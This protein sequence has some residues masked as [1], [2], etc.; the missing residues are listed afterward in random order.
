MKNFSRITDGLTRVLSYLGMMGI[1]AMMLHICADVL[2]RTL[3]GLSVPA[4]LEMV[5]RYYMLMLVLLSLAWV[6]DK[7]QMIAVEAFTGM[8][9]KAGL[10]VV[11]LLV[12]VFCIIV[13]SVLAVSTWHKAT[14]QY[15]IGAYVVALDTQII[16]WPGY[17]TLPF[18]FGLAALVCLMKI[19]LNLIT[20]TASAAA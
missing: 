11:H 7:H 9:G 16:V 12:T 17:F 14:E 4:T 18:G 10:R 5:T 20:K 8:F 2:G 19:L 6:E 1:L 13:Y 15:D 3:L